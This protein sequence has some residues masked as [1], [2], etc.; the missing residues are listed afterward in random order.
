[1]VPTLAADSPS[2]KAAAREILKKYQ[3]AI[4]AV[5][6]VTKFGQREMQVE[7]AGTV[8]T[9][10]G[11]TVVS[12][13][14]SNPGRILGGDDGG[15]ETTEVQPPLRDGQELPAKFVLRDRDLDL[16]FVLPNEKGLNLPHVKLEK[17]PIPEVLD[18]LIYLQRLG[19]SLNREPS[20]SLGHV[21]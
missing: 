3:D 6:L 21:A 12:D 10:E 17:A 9:P 11:L 13:F 19:K 7:V 15:N 14:S 1:V 16:A 5:K 4:V 20:V 2:P 18:D 8:L